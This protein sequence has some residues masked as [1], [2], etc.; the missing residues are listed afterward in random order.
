MAKTAENAIGE[1]LKTAK[2]PG[3]P[4]KKKKCGMHIRIFNAKKKRLTKKGLPKIGNPVSKKSQTTFPQFPPHP[5][6]Q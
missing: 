1:T 5:S 3:L 2:E 4:N 6:A